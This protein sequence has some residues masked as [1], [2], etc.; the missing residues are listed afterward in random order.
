LARRGADF[1]RPADNDKRKA[2]GQDNGIPLS[3]V[4]LFDNK[5]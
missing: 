3:S 4:M 2:G 5:K 1:K